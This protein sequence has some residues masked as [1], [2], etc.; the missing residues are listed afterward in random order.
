[1]LGLELSSS[2]VGA[3]VVIMKGVQG[4]PSSEIGEWM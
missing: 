3:R 2:V 4:K 1:M